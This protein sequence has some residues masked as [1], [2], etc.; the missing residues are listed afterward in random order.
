MLRV[1][2]MGLDI[3]SVNY[4]GQTVLH[5]MAK[6]GFKNSIDALLKENVDVNI[7]DRWGRTALQVLHWL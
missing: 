1:V 7:H 3:N 5:I 6:H 2:H 4:D